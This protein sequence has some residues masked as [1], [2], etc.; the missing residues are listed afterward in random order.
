MDL[1]KRPPWSDEAVRR[2]GDALR[3]GVEPPTDGPSYDDV[4]RWYFDL[5]AEVQMQIEEGS[6]SIQPELVTSKA[7]RMDTDLR[8]GSRSK[9]RDTLVQKL[10]RR[11]T[12]T[13]DSVQ[14][15]AG[16]RVDAD[17]YLGEQTQLAR[18]IAE[19][20]GN[21]ETVI[22]DR[23]DGAKAGY[24]GIHVDLQLPAGRVEVQV[25]TILQSLWANVYEKLADE[26]GRGIR[27]GEAAVPPPGYDQAEVDNAVQRMQEMSEMIAAREAEWQEYYADTGD[28]MRGVKLGTCAMQKAMMV[29]SFVVGAQT[30]NREAEAARETEED[31]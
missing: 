8:I 5:A 3:D 1:M 13:L 22:V 30:A 26:V 31:G 20:F 10:R 16:V 14:D 9:T 27:Y 28:F 6:W 19:H 4:L 2:L 7:V 18:E 29:A 25:R 15:L 12:L 24:R 11:P 23:R 17:V 21:D